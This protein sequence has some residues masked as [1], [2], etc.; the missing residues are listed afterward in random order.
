MDAYIKYNFKS[1]HRNGCMNENATEM[2][3][4]K[5]GAHIR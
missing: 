3:A 1:M 4:Q 5:I 2:H